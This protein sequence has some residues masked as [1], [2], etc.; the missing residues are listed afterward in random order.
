MRRRIRLWLLLALPALVVCSTDGEAIVCGADVCEVAGNVN[1][2]P[3]VVGD[4]GNFATS[5]DAVNDTLVGKPPENSGD[6]YAHAWQFALTERA[7]VTGTLTKNNT[8]ANF[9]QHPVSLQLFSQS[10][11][12]NNIGGTFQVP[13]DSQQNPF[14]AFSFADLAPGIYFFKVAGTLIGNDGQYA[15][16]LSVNAVPLPPAVWLFLTA[17]V[18]LATIVR[19]PRPKAASQPARTARRLR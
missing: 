7:N 13:F 19:K 5:V 17:V 8:L 10:D 9:Q 14:V 15:G 1:G 3:L 12:A 6:S 18:G 4:S 11:L 16:Q 2:S